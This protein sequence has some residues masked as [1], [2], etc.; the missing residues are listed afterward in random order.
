VTAIIDEGVITPWPGSNETSDNAGKTW[1]G[2]NFLFCA[3]YGGPCAIGRGRTLTTVFS[4]ENGV[5]DP[6]AESWREDYKS[7]RT[8]SWFTDE[9]FP[10]RI[11][12]QTRSVTSL[13]EREKIRRFDAFPW[14]E[15][16]K[17]VKDKEPKFGKGLK[18]K[19]AHGGYDPNAHE[20]EAAAES[21]AHAPEAKRNKP[22]LD[23][24][25]LATARQDERVSGARVKALVAQS[26]GG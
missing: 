6:K 3:T 7:T 5:A 26:H 9:S 12:L 17:F 25:E 23:S 22:Q 20:L 19:K 10:H 24:R 15:F 21:R 8:G 4:V 14:D 16:D 11:F 13:G 2:K 1:S 18:A